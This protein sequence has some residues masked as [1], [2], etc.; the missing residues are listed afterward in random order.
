MKRNRK[1][2]LSFLGII[3]ILTLGI[4]LWYL[5]SV[6]TYKDK[7]ASIAIEDIDL[8]AI[9]DGT[10]I[11]EYDVDFIYAKVEVIVQDGVI[12]NIN[13]LKH[14]N[15]KGKPAEQ[16]ID[17]IVRTQNLDVDAISGATNSSQVIKKA[18]E[19]ALTMN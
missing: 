18:I 1:I 11:G 4:L 12:T 19:N 16:I 17:N 13:L 6:Q 3:V 7:V 5:Y 8:A 15:G 9:P 10:Y 2:L 14:K